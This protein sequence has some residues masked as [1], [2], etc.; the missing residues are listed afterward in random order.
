MPHIM[1][2]AAA[3]T[4]S[5]RLP[6]PSSAEQIADM[7]YALRGG[8]LSLLAALARDFDGDGRR[9]SNAAALLA[10]AADER[11]ATACVTRLVEL[12]RA[13]DAHTARRRA[14]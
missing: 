8:R 6:R 11:R 2:Q 4:S 10:E 9:V 12:A 14:A 13:N 5:L 7:A 1:A 3:S